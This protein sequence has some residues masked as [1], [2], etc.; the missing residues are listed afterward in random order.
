M[1][2]LLFAGVPCL[3]QCT[4]ASLVNVTIDD[5]FGDPQTGALV[6]YSPASAWENGTRACSTACVARPDPDKLYNGT[7]HETT[8]FI[9]DSGDSKADKHQM[10]S[11]SVTFNG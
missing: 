7:W 9:P 2:F 11:A 4:L 6:I 3:I 10:S 1:R 5:T 8:T